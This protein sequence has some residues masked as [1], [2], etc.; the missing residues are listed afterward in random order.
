MP[1]F[2]KLSSIVFLFVAQT[3]YAETVRPGRIVRIEV[4]DTDR[5]RT[6]VTAFAVAVAGGPASSFASKV[7]DSNYHVKLGR[8]ATNASSYFLELQRHGPMKKTSLPDVELNV[9]STIEASQRHVIGLIERP[10]GSRTEVALTL[11]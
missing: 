8:D 6:E 11:R 5:N 9:A 10:D 1:H 7:G 2:A 3:A 4:T